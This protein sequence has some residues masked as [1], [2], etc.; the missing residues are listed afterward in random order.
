[1]FF[2]Y[3]K[4]E[5]KLNKFYNNFF[6]IFFLIIITAIFFVLTPC[7]FA[8]AATIYTNSSTGNDSTGDGSLENPYKTFYKT[9]TVASTGDTL[10][11]T[12]TFDWSDADEIGDIDI[13]GFTLSKALTIQGHGV[14]QT[15]IQAASA[16]NTA[17]KKV[18]T[19]AA[20]YGATF[21]DLTIRY[22]YNSITE[23]GGTAIYA[24]YSNSPVTLIN[25][26]I[27]QNKNHT[28]RYVNGAIYVRGALI[29]R[30]TTVSNNEN[31]YAGGIYYT[32]TGAEITNCTFYN[33]VGDYYGG[34]YIS[35]AS[36]A[37]TITNSTLV[38]NK[39]NYGFGGNL[40]IW[41][42]SVYL[43]N[44]IL[45]DSAGGVDYYRDSATPIHDNGYNIVETQ[46]YSDLTNG[47][48]GNIVGNQA[49]LNIDSALAS[50][51]SRNGVPNLALF[52]NSVAIDA[53]DDVANNSISVPITDQ[54]E[55]N[56]DSIIDIGAFEY[57]GVDPTLTYTLTYSAGAG[58]SISGTSSQDVLVGSDGATVTAIPDSGYRFVDWSDSSTDNPRTDT[59]V[60]SNVSV[61]AN[62]EDA[63]NPVVSNVSS[64]ASSNSVEIVWQTNEQ[65]S[66]Q[67]EYGLV[68]SYGTST[69]ETDTS[70]RVLDHSVDIDSLKSCAQYYYRVKSKDSANNQSVSSQETF[71]TTG[72]AFS[73]IEDGNSDEVETSGG[74]V[75]LDTDDGGVTLQAPENFYSEK[76]TI[77]INKLN[78]TSPPSLPSGKNLAND[79]FFNL[80]AVS[81]SGDTVENFD[82]PVTF[83]ISYGS[84]LENAYV[85]NTLGVYKYENGSWIDKNCVLDTSAN[86]LTCTLP[87]FSV[88]GVLG[89]EVEGD[90]NEAE[91]ADVKSWEAFRYENLNGVSC[92]EKL[93]LTIKG[94][95]FE[96][97]VDVKI[98]NIEAY[99]IKRKSSKKIVANFC[100][101]DLLDVKTD[102]VRKVK[103]INPDAEEDV[104]K[105]RINLNSLLGQEKEPESTVLKN[106]DI[107]LEDYQ[108]DVTSKVCNYTVED[109]DN[110]WSVAKKV[111][112]DATAYPLI[113]SA[114][115]E[116]YPEIESGK[117]SI[118]Q[119]FIFDC[120]KNNTNSGNE[121][122]P[123]DNS[124]SKNKPNTNQKNQE[125]DFH[126]WNPLAWF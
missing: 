18:F 90:E 88:Y 31:G 26:W 7:D 91:K 69:V 17:G 77:Q 99:K 27:D 121:V 117:L 48:N 53:G 5:K 105:K 25:C 63:I 86:T 109:G 64:T 80:L 81:E 61:T 3:K 6:G 112:G 51:N 60:S 21:E 32:G 45:A 59:N 14:D 100:F 74:S 97:G 111:Y 8:Q 37:T 35:N 39:S 15:I 66:S 33:N 29:M 10:D 46:S 113:I 67:V 24:Q 110:L 102:L 87:S 58:G 93:K 108:G 96:K 118:G 36:G 52:E 28:T 92:P 106:K 42:S 94:S 57:D 13:T 83:T 123:A 120:E 125:D 9:Y 49:N 65:T 43:K 19:L 82:E 84:S 104:A 44:T 22:G 2:S 23:S 122:T 38:N 126:W 47:V 50:N 95:D 20:G 40:S 116:K 71:I 30:N 75:T 124:E 11:L 12:G 115:K 56:R 73:Q 79:N 34:L 114:N 72:C 119:E 41:Y 55:F 70:P 78:T 68:S 1:M 98:G 76:T 4:Y 85:E 103:I 54:R 62:F 89:E 16:P 107:L 101:T